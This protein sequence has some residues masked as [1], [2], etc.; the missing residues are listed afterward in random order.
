[1]KIRACIYA[2]F[3]G[4]LIAL[5]THEMNFLMDPIPL[6]LLQKNITVPSQ[7][8]LTFIVFIT[9]CVISVLGLVDK[10]LLS[11]KRRKLGN[12]KKPPEEN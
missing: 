11:L 7:I 1:M 8:L 9:L 6:D 5:L 3:I 4:I 10:A 12:D 2:I